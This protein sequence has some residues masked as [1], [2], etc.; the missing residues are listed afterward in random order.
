MIFAGHCSKQA[1]GSSSQCVYMCVMFICRHVQKKAVHW[2][3]LILQI[4]HLPAEAS[5][6]RAGVAVADIAIG[7]AFVKTE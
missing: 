3:P 1:L 4:E 5:L 2:T 6:S 7:A